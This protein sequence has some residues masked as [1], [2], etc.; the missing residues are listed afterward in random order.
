MPCHGLYPRMIILWMR[1]VAPAF[2]SD[3]LDSGYGGECVGFF[4]DSPG[5][6]L[7][8]ETGIGRKVFYIVRDDGSVTE[9]KLDKIN[10][11]LPFPVAKAVLPD[12]FINA[13]PGNWLKHLTLLISLT[14]KKLSV[15]KMLLIDITIYNSN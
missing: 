4:F 6:L 10:E 15:N 7:G 2:F 12:K 1:L 14:S 13:F 3:K 5:N 9:L 11:D 8:S